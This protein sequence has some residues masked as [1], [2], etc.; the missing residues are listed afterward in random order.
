MKSRF[1]QIFTIALLCATALPDTIR[2]KEEAALEI[3][4]KALGGRKSLQDVQ[5]IH[6]KGTVETGG[7]KGTYERWSSSRG[8]FRAALDLSGAIRQLTIFDGHQGWIEMSGTV[9]E[10]SGSVL[11]GVLSGAYEASNSF[12]FSGRMPG[13]VELADEYVVRL[14]PEGG[15]AVTVYLD[16]QT[17]LPSREESAGPL[18]TRIVSFSDWREFSGIQIPGTI[19]QSNGD[20]K[21]DEAVSD[22]AGTLPFRTVGEILMRNGKEWRVTIVRDDFNM[23]AS[24]TAIPIHHVFLTDQ[25]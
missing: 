21:Y 19:R 25:L 3:W 17:G 15:N 10:L 2:A 24:R 5:T 12:L 18:G 23:S 9:Q 1:L 13:R 4:A 16:R 14:Q 11:K 7:L 8:E 6:I 20:P 22:S